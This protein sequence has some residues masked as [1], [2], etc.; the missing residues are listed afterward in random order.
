MN[1]KVLLVIVA[2]LAAVIVIISLTGNED[3][4]FRSKVLIIDPDAITGLHVY[5]PQSK[6]DIKL[7]RNSENS[8]TL[9]KGDQ[10]YV[11]DEDAVR[12]VLHMLNDMQTESVVTRQEEKWEEYQVNESTGINVKLFQDDELV[13]ELYIGKFTYKVDEDTK[14]NAMMGRQQNTKMTSYVRPAE[15]DNVYALNGILRM[16]FT[17]GSSIYRKKNIMDQDYES[18]GKLTYSYP[19]KE[20]ILEKKGTKWFLN[21]QPADSAATV[22]YLRS[23]ARLRNSSFIDTANIGGMQPSHKLEVEGTGFTPVIVEAYPSQDSTIGYYITSSINPGTVWNGNTGNLFDKI[24]KT[25]VDFFS[26]K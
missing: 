19:G 5:D 15:E 12:N 17:N 16:N 6:E 8:W 1:Y 3:R 14:K 18:L 13:D 11:G 24:F 20:L 23:L 22:K 26:N 25:E 4:T 21:E 10:E 9:H 2:I 7:V